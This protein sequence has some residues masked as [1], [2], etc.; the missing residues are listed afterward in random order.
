MANSLY[1]VHELMV[2]A[3]VELEE[4]DKKH[5]ESIAEKAGDLLSKGM[6][7]AA[8]ASFDE[9]GE[10]LNKKLVGLGKQPIVFSDIKI[11]ERALD[12]MISRFVSTI[13]QGM[14]DGFSKVNIAPQIDFGIDEQLKQLK[15]DRQKL[16][17]EYEK[18]KK[19][20]KNKTEI[21]DINKV[22]GENKKLTLTGD[23]KQHTDGF[24]KQFEN[25]VKIM[26]SATKG[27][28]EYT[29]AVFEAQTALD[30]LG[31]IQSE[32][33][34]KRE[35]LKETEAQ[36]RKILSA[37]IS[38]AN[39]E[40]EKALKAKLDQ[41]KGLNINHQ[42]DKLSNL[43]M[44]D[45]AESVLIAFGEIS[46]AFDE[47]S[48][49]L[50]QIETQIKSL[51][52]QISELEN[53]NGT[54]KTLQEIEKAYDRILK[55]KG[56]AKEKSGKEKLESAIKYDGSESLTTLGN[57][58]K[59]SNLAGEDWE[60]QYILLVKFVKEYQSI[61]DFN[62]T[63]DKNHRKKITPG[64]TELYNKLLPMYS[65]AE[66]SLN[67]LWA[68][69]S[70]M[71]SGEGAAKNL[72]VQENV[73]KVMQEQADAASKIANE[74]RKSIKVAE[75]KLKVEK[76]ILD[77]KKSAAENERLLS[78]LSS[79]SNIDKEKFAYLNTDT[80]YASQHIVGE[81]GQVSKKAQQELLERVEEEVNA[82]LHTHPELIAAPSEDDIQNFA[83][84]HALFKKNFILAGEQLAEIDFTGLSETQAK[85]LANAYKQNV[86]N[87]E[88]E[89][90]EKFNY[91]SFKD[92]GIDSLDID[93]ILI[94][95]SEHL[96]S[97][98]P[99]LQEDINKYIENLRSMFKGIKIEDL[100]QNQLEGMIDDVMGSN[101]KGSSMDLRAD[102]YQITQ[103]IINHASGVP[104]MYQ[105]ALRDIFTKTIRDLNF[106]Q[107]KIFKLHNVNDFDSQL[108]IIREQSTI[109]YK[110]NAS[111][112]K[113]A[114]AAQK[115]LSQTIPSEEDIKGGK[116]SWRGVPIQY[117][118]ALSG[119]ARNLTDF[120]KVGP[121]FF[122]M[123]EEAQKYILDHE[124]AHNIADR[125]MD[126]ATD[127]WEK[128]ADIFA[129]KKL[130][131]KGA[132]PSFYTEEDNEGN[133]WYRE[134][135]YGDLG[136]T[137]LSETL[138]HA[139]TEYF[140]NPDSFKKR[141]EG[142]FNYLEEYLNKSGDNLDNAAVDA[143][144]E[145]L[146]VQEQLNQAKKESDNIDDDTLEE[147]KQE[148]G[149]LEDK[150]ERLQ[151]LSEEWG[152]K[153]SQKKRDRYEE[154]N[155]KDM[156]E[157][158]T[159]A[160]ENR[161]SELYDEI[162]EADDALEEFGNTYE[163]IIL[164]LANGK[165]VEILPDDKGLSSLYKV[166]DEYGESYNGIEIDDVIFERKKEEVAV[167]EDLNEVLEEQQQIEQK[168]DAVVSNNQKKIESYEEL[169]GA[170]KQYLDL[171]SQLKA[172]EHTDED[173]YWDSVSDRQH[174]G[175]NDDGSNVNEIFQSQ[176]KKVAAI[177]KSIKQGADAYID[178][179]LKT[180][181]RIGEDT[182]EREEKTLK[183][184]ITGWSTFDIGKLN[185]AQKKYANQVLN[186]F[187]A[188]EKD[189][190]SRYAVSEE[191][192]KPIEEQVRSIQN[193]IASQANDSFL[194]WR[195]FEFG[196]D[197]KGMTD[198]IAPALGI[199]IPNAAETAKQ[200]IDEL[201]NSIEKQHQVANAD[202]ATD[203][204]AETKAE[205]D[206][207]AQQNEKLK[208]NI[209]L[210]QM[211]EN[212]SKHGVPGQSVAEAAGVAVSESSGVGVD[213][214]VLQN[215][216]IA[217]TYNV[218]I[219]H[220]DN[221]RNANKI[222]LDDST[223]EATLNKVFSNIL[224]PVTEQNDGKN[225]E[226]GPWA[227]ENTLSTTIK[228][229]LDSINANTSKIGTSETVTIADNDVLSAI[230]TAVESINN[231]IVQG[232]K[233]LRTSSA[234]KTEEKSADLE[235][236]NP[237]ELG[238]VKATMV[239]KK[240]KDLEALYEEQ[241]RLESQLKQDPDDGVTKLDLKEIKEKI[242]LK[243]EG[244]TLD[245]QELES[246][247]E[248]AKQSANERLEA[249]KANEARKQ[250]AKD[251]KAELKARIKQS[252]EENRFGASTTAWNTGNKA[253]ESL[254]KI[255]D[256]ESPLEIK[257]VKDLQTALIELNTV[258]Q[259]VNEN[260]RKGIEISSQDS[261]ELRDKT[262]QVAKHTEAVKQL[263]KNY[264]DLSGENVT[265]TGR[266]I[267]D[268]NV[269]SQLI[270]AAKALTNGKARIGEYDA[271]TQ[272][273]KYT[274]KTGAYEFQEYEMAVREAGGAIV[275]VQGAT[276]RTETFIEGF[277]RKLS[278]ITRYFS[279]SSLIFKFFN[280]F[281]KGVQYVKEIDSAL[282][283][284]RKVTDE[285][286]E[287]YDEFLNTAAK[288]ANKLGSTISA[289]TEATATFAKLGYSMDMASE[290]AEAAIVYKNVG[291]NIA[292]TEDAA[293]SI[294]S[295]LKGF[296]LEASESMKI[297]DRFNEVGNKFAITSQ[298]IG[299]AL[300]LSASALNEGGNTLDESIGIITAANEVVNDP[301][302][303]GTALKTLTLRLR[304][305]KTELEEMGEDVSDMA[306]TTS[307]LQAKLLALTGG[308][309]NIMLDE[310]TFKSSTQILRE[311]AA[312][313]EDMT[314][315]QQ[316]DCCLYVQKCA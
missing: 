254:W 230:K 260:L 310:N 184:L 309:V 75:T 17:D 26:N 177:K 145:E 49:K 78:K 155:Q 30:Q 174:G 3:G 151:Q 146:A 296:G 172:M 31:A 208:E 314:D 60:D 276:K 214:Q 8:S 15:A 287:T 139:L 133:R 305:S 290:M 104:S 228:G 271:A 128:V 13:S 137:A 261:N 77:T 19:L 63:A 20:L 165:K 211:V 52:N 120:M 166:G 110:E 27:T 11:D 176:W 274:L 268:G 71:Q 300:R 89:L 119:E 187:N 299:E 24:I 288:T 258:R 99:D 9:I 294:I 41:L 203:E 95:A 232:T 277:K 272:K 237:K 185:D 28:E 182:L 54:L 259:R 256:K 12:N 192:N 109:A 170:V 39:I 227:L 169:T 218:K 247:K 303:V 152:H 207:I 96:M 255:D 217:I 311:M 198:A 147:I 291:D 204:V 81:Y 45:D 233:V 1:K 16:L 127:E 191:Y 229:V 82:T 162:T 159:S 38:K 22:L 129:P 253:L 34:K 138:T 173:W 242:D 273:L 101:F 215:V 199:E 97:Q 100:S 7:K 222:A 141:S 130:L 181:V 143:V 107:S 57:R 14:K 108:A 168:S 167:Q 126:Q 2:K 307:Q 21:N 106:D 114:T 66:K 94:K 285:T 88:D 246:L 90:D 142:A 235:I 40:K 286:E 59:A 25:A 220:D 194:A 243:K 135:L 202:D 275:S 190:E 240:V 293:D 156:D 103:D 5:I 42:I 175:V 197:V 257:S 298:G 111:A 304:G 122:G 312:A 72:S 282:I 93:G 195:G 306:A 163:K 283:E 74:E 206:A 92:L 178:P 29:S 51:N 64:H 123:D 131:P 125:I 269:E 102:I 80:G 216:L 284:L 23:I 180:S 239:N 46:D 136:A 205:T 196:D 231:K 84:N 87:A 200:S 224:N 248:K 157:G 234:K 118:S 134:G 244:L 225:E 221:D 292:S 83:N 249:E 281:K 76:E 264:D 245:A 265:D 266:V 121:K 43:K 164:K 56:N 98:F 69:V 144:K 91:T 267:A 48:N 67:D 297:V 186:A 36:Y 316:A 70:P 171:K 161:M 149:T 132:N 183:Q 153:I 308:K 279:A 86:L 37:P 55:K 148:T 62:K 124:V 270:S 116:A 154:L 193:S 112:V 10:I 6:V 241:Y 33:H 295:T 212:A 79:T 68:K 210:K 201:T 44:S 4:V 115:G 117:D 105:E 73:T 213:K 140:S 250:A 160:E 289:V 315:I 313:W 32:W 251:E 263:V 18:T 223:L 58:Y 65:S 150:L 252:K 50:E 209:S 179:E 188:W 53:N 113:D 238:N 262:E 35:E 85:E 302:S 301:S 189:W 61:L 47:V 236:K 219:V 226:V 158:L 278:E 280:E